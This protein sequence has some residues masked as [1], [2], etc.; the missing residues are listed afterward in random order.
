MQRL[1]INLEN[2]VDS[3]AAS[4]D[5]AALPVNGQMRAHRSNVAFNV[6]LPI[7]SNDE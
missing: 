4:L 6:R 1:L 5:R 2:A 7:D 3:A